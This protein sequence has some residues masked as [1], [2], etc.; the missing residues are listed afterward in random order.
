MEVDGRICAGVMPTIRYRKTGGCM[1]TY[2]VN[3]EIS[4]DSIEIV[5]DKME[6]AIRV[7]QEVAEWARGAGFRVWPQEWLTRDELVSDEAK[8]EN[9]FIGMLRGRI[10]CAFILQWSDSEY[11]PDAPAYEAAYIHKLCVCR[12]FAH[13]GMT[14]TIVAAVRR[15]CM[16]KGIRYIRLDVGLDERKIRKI[17]LNAGFKIVDI[18]DY[19][20]GNSMAL[21]E[22]EV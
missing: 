21:Y 3:A 9:F 2:S 20:N 19:E 8:P 12:E 18:I 14:K 16:E 5:P 22:M 15:L 11:W 1:E 17:Y 4:A 10:V 13:C 6:D 7:M